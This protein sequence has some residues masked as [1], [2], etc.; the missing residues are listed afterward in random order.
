MRPTAFEHCLFQRGL[1]QKLFEP[2]VLLLQLCQPAGLLGLH[3]PVFLPPA[4]V[5]RLSHLDHA[6]EV[7][8][9]FALGDQ[10]LV[11]S[12]LRKSL[13]LALAADLL[14]CVPGRFMLESPAQSGRMRS[15]SPWS[16]SHGSRQ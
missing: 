4:V 5:C 8:D 10:L 1:C 11:R 13:R 14:G 6:A 15:H 2:G 12:L 7:G 16:D 9:G 3:T